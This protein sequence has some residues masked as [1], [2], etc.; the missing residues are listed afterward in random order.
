MVK[1]IIEELSYLEKKVLLTLK[2]LEVATPEKIQENGKFKELVEVMNASSW[3]K[4]KKLVEISEHLSTYYTLAKK[5]FATRDLPERRALRIL[6]KKRGLANIKDF[7]RSSKLK[8]KEVPIAIG[9]LKRK[10]WA[11]ISKEKGEVIFRMTDE[12]KKAIEEK[13]KDEKLIELLA[14]GWVSDDEVDMETMRMLLSRQDIVRTRDVIKREIRLTDLGKEVLQRGIELK[15]KVAQLTPQLIQTGKWREV[16]LRKYDI[17]TFAPTIYGGRFHPLS[18]LM[19]QIKEI[20]LEMGFTEIS[21]NFVQSCFWNM[22]ALF[23]PQDHPARELQ[24]T[25]YLS[26]PEKINLVDKKLVEK[27]KK[28]HEHGGDTISDGWRYKWNDEEA[29]KAILRTHTTESTIK[30]LS[31]HPKPPVKVFSI[32]RIFRNEATDATHL[33]ELHQIEGIVMEKNA[34]LKMLI[35]I[36]KEFYKRMGFEKIRFRPGYFPYTEPSIEGDVLFEGKWL[37]L[38]AAG[39]FRPEVTAPFGVNH[40]VLAWGL[41]L[42]R[43]AMLKLGLNDIRKLYTNDIEWLRNTKI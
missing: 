4:S 7:Q 2:D 37:E 1:E 12:G 28:M 36:L 9:W 41:G 24:D 16:E 26:E 18:D 5:Q 40:P 21:G 31:Q 34:D 23:I 38:A 19:E 8:N 35:G 22:D 14:K 33:A 10:G 25:F 17:H 11:T 42:E 27:I 6:K 30:Y 15:E 32:G 39:I 29:E 13:G 3:L 43:L 20:F